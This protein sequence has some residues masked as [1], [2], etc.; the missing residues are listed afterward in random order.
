MGYELSE[1]ASIGSSCKIDL[2]NSEKDCCK[3][4]KDK[5][6]KLI[7]IFTCFQGTQKLSNGVF[8]KTNEA[9]YQ[10]DSHEKKTRNI[11]HSMG[12]GALKEN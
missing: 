11:E 10:I 6:I 1:V 4:Y 12:K 3:I 7:P 8:L 9:K 2:K 5:F